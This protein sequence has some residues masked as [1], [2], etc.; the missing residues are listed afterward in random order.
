MRG[1]LPRGA[2]AE[3]L[4]ERQQMRM[5][6]RAKDQRQR[7]GAPILTWVGTPRISL[8]FLAK[9]LTSFFHSPSSL[10]HFPLFASLI[11]PASFFSI[12]FA[13]AREL[14]GEPTRGGGRGMLI[15]A[16]STS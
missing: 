9:E 8:P 14:R 11:S 13:L 3:V 16:S 2:E 12:Y 5:L 15:H 4:S 6:Q 1:A 7:H 10:F